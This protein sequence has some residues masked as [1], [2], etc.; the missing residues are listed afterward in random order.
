MLDNCEHLL[1]AA[2]RLVEAMVRACPGVCVLATSREGLGV[3]GERI[4]VVRSLGLPATD[5][6][7]G[8][9]GG[10]GR[11]GPVVL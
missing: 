11:C 3:S 1:D 2:A 10:S 4:L 8:R 7:P 5:G 9:P 6:T